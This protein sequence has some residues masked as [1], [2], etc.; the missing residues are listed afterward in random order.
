MIVPWTIG[1]LLRDLT[2]RGEHP[3]VISCGEDGVMTCGSEAL[4]EKAFDATEF[5]YAFLQAF[6]N[7]ETTIKRLRA[8]AV[9]CL[10]NRP[11]FRPV[12]EPRV[13]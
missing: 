5:S 3:A 6:G 13:A 12:T 11:A 8:G 7:K 9:K 2:A 1:G 4:A 10:D